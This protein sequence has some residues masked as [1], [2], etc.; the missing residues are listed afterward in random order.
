MNPANSALSTVFRTSLN[1]FSVA[2]GFKYLLRAQS[3]TKITRLT[4]TQV[5]LQRKRTLGIIVLTLNLCF[6]IR[7]IDL[8]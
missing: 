6:R 8:L 7:V 3:D 1:R 2:V 5:D 4:P